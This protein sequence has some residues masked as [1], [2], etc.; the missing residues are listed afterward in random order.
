[1]SDLHFDRALRGAA[2][3]GRPEGVCPDAAA[4]ASYVDRSL[5]PDERAALEAHIASC[6]TCMEHLALLA[7]V[8]APEPPADPS[9]VWSFERVFGQLALAGAGGHRRTRSRSLAAAARIARPAA[10]GGAGEGRPAPKP[11]A[12]LPRLVA[13]LREKIP[14]T[15]PPNSS[16]SRMHARSS[17]L[18]TSWKRRDRKRRKRYRLQSAQVDAF[19]QKERDEESANERKNR[20]MARAR[21]VAPVPLRRRHRHQPQVVEEAKAEAGARIESEGGCRCRGQPQGERREGAG[22]GGDG[23]RSEAP[24]VA[25]GANALAL[26]KTIAAPAFEVTAPGVRLRVVNGR[27]ERSSDGGAT[28]TTERTGVA[29]RVLS[30]DCPT[31]EVCWLA[32]DAGQVFVRAAGGTWADRPIAEATLACCNQDLVADAATAT[33]ADG[34]RFSTTDG[35]RTW[36]LAQ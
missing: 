11:A 32:G 16:S 13:R 28:W 22:D 33:L 35:G 24:G 26:R 1:M 20:A 30:G 34:R 7:A 23:G 27:F 10:P 12:T 19:K 14:Q 36:T 17:M 15:S 21:P 25:V 6:P 8:D 5:S 4:L 18:P 9:V 2:R 3:R 31:A 29:T